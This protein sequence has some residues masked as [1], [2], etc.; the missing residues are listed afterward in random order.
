MTQTIVIF[1]ASGDLTQRK[2]IPSLYNLYRK[3]RLEDGIRIVGMA[4]DPF[5]DTSFRKHLHEGY[6]K[7]VGPIP[8]PEKWRKFAASIHYQTGSFDSTDD[9]DKLHQKLHKLEKAGDGRLYY[10][11]TSPQFYE[12]IASQLGTL[13][14]E[15][16]HHGWRRIVVE[17]PFGHDRASAQALNKAILSVFDESQVYRID[18]YLGKETVQNVLVFRFGNTIFEPVWN[19]N[20]IEEVQI[21]VSESI[22][23]GHRAGYY[24]KSGVLRDMFQNHLLQLLALIAMEPPASLNADAQ[25][26]ERTK[27]LYSIRPMTADEVHKNTVRGQY[28]SYTSE[29]GVAP[30]SQTPTYAALRMYVDNWRWQDVPFYLRS[31]KMMTDKLTEMV[32]RFRKP[33]HSFFPH[34]EGSALTPNTLSICVAPDEGIHLSFETKVPDSILE[35]QSVNMEFHYKPGEI[36]EAYERLILDALHGDPTLFARADTIDLAW[37]II[38]PI[39]AAWESKN[40]PPIATYADGTWGPAEGEA[41]LAEDHNEWLYQCGKHGIAVT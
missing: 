2:L 36:P 41:L 9:F 20:Y 40:A 8:E 29:D 30:H 19:R 27:V 10:L 14:M 28:K 13:D 16:E 11:S 3:G 25:R 38:D 12:V 21:T 31:G 15:V 1:G 22:G 7:L 4:I 37:G 5:D 23:V 34:I 35:S 32:I 33:P 26:N 39:L 17:K 6:E 24:E 18:H